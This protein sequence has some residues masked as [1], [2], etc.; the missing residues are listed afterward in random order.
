[1]NIAKRLLFYGY[2]PV[3][4]ERRYDTRAEAEAHR[5]Q[6][7]VRNRR[8]ATTYRCPACGGVH[9]TSGRSKRKG[10]T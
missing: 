1:M 5:R 10:K 7:S 3:S 2:C 6:I 8:K 9:I 4:G